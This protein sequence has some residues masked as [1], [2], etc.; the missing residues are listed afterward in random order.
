MV[1]WVSD[2]RRIFKN[3]KWQHR[4]DGRCLEKPIFIFLYVNLDVFILLNKSSQNIQMKTGCMTSHIN[5]T[6]AFISV[7]PSHNRPEGRA[8]WQVPGV[9]S[10]VKRLRHCGME[11]VNWRGPVSF[12]VD[13]GRCLITDRVGERETEKKRA[14][15]ETGGEMIEGERERE[16][17][18]FAEARLSVSQQLSCYS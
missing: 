9:E 8:E 5:V 3:E 4:P 6:F 12:L 18:C 15:R 2:I 1:L 16:R 7:R 14:R 17:P 10:D 13:C 11:G